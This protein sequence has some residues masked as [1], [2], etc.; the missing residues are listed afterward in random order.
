M[1]K[2][3]KRGGHLSGRGV[4]TDGTVHVDLLGTPNEQTQGALNN[5]C[6]TVENNC[7]LE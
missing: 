6:W 1:T 3:N 7:Y 4:F 2:Y 5:I